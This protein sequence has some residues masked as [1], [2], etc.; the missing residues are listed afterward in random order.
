MI[1]FVECSIKSPSLFQSNSGEFI[2]F[3]VHVSDPPLRE[4]SDVSLNQP[5]RLCRRTVR[6]G[7]AFP[8]A[9]LFFLRLRLIDRRRSLQS[10]LEM[11]R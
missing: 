1:W 10:I 9:T 2:R 4:L 7:S 3:T 6:K 5:V 11:Q 8:G